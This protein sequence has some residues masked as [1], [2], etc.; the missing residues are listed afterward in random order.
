MKIVKQGNSY[1]ECH[2]W[3]S[4]KSDELLNQLKRLN[5]TDIMT[6]DEF[7]DLID[8]VDDVY[9]NNEFKKLVECKNKNLKLHKAN[10]NKF[11]S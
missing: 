3:L 7:N 4:N 10:K 6:L 2:K 8:S 1:V 5:H 11:Y 9:E